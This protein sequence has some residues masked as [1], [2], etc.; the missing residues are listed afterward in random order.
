MGWLYYWNTLLAFSVV[1]PSLAFEP[2]VPWSQHGSAVATIIK[3]PTSLASSLLP[4]EVR[5]DSQFEIKSSLKGST[6]TGSFY[7]AEYDTSSSVTYNE[8]IVSS[9]TLNFAPA[10]AVAGSNTNSNGTGNSSTTSYSGGWLSNVYVDD[11]NALEA[12]KE[13]WGI[14]KKLAV[15]NRSLAADGQTRTVRVTDP[16]TGALIVAATYLEGGGAAFPWSSQETTLSVSLDGAGQVL[17]SATPEN[18]R[19]APVDSGIAFE[20]PP[21][22]P[23]YGLLGDG[24]AASGVARRGASYTRKGAVRCAF[25]VSLRFRPKAFCT[26]WQP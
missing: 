4:E 24:G 5:S 8:L 12:G 18:F 17:Y 6:T 26:G 16:D 23:L 2:P 13:V 15:F 19:V 25:C 21:G 11:E 14:D 20:I 9:A 10:A 3:V 1:F 7:L 22:S